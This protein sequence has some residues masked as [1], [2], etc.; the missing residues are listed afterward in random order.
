MSLWGWL[1]AGVAGME[2]HKLSEGPLQPSFPSCYPLCVHTL[3][4]SMGRS[5]DNRSQTSHTWRSLAALQV[6]LS[7]AAH[8]SAMLHHPSHQNDWPCKW[9]PKRM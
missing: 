4:P 3:H 7:H 6:S 9:L 5:R 8:I 1:L 2:V